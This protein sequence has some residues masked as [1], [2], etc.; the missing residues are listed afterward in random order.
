MFNKL[1]EVR[2]VLKKDYS[3]VQSLRC[4]DVVLTCLRLGHTCIAHSHLLKRDEQ[5]QCVSCKKPFT[6]KHFLLEGINFLDIRK[7]YFNVR[8]FKHQNLLLCLGQAKH[9]NPLDYTKF[10]SKN[11]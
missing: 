1:H 5:P 2:P 4:E 6:V 8:N 7:Q 3:V 9:N 11:L 10:L